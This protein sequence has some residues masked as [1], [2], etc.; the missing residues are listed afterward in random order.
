MKLLSFRTRSYLEQLWNAICG[1]EYKTRHW[2][3]Y[4]LDLFIIQQV[5][6]WVPT[7]LEGCSE[8]N[9]WYKDVE[10]LWEVAKL[11]LHTCDIDAENK[12]T[13][14]FTE[15]LAKNFNHLWY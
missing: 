9:K 15:L 7:I 3:I 14:E 13:K 6:N 5:A 11:L 12:L 4:N 8:D 2:D 10:R 1:V